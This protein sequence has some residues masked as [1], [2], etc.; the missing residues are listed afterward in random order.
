MK[1]IK[2]GSARIDEHGKIVGGEV[3]DQTK[4]EVSTQDYYI[5]SK[6]WY[7][8]RPKS[9]TVAKKLAKAM[10]EA[11]KNDKIGYDQSNRLGVITQ[12]KKAGSL[13]KIS[14]DTEADCSSL[15][16]ACCIQSG[17]D[18]GN[19]STIN[20]ASALEATGKFKNRVSVSR[21]I[22]L[23][24]GDVLV[25]K[26]KGHTVIVVSGNTRLD[27]AEAVSPDLSVY[28]V[29]RRDTLSKIAKK[30]GTTV[31]KLVSLNGIKDK[32]KIRVGQKLKLK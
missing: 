25:T 30:H 18:P 32:N 12:L 5:S 10:K 22:S 19:F 9:A 4:K 17:F 26:T 13:R 21:D 23:C 1:T 2:V 24:T 15:V 27:K 28:T 14:V 11:C 16:R 29:K 8:L 20:E 6:G 3:G 7:L 31:A